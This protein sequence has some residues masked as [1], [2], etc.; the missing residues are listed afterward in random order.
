MA[1]ATTQK[2]AACRLFALNDLLLSRL[3]STASAQDL[4]RLAQTCRQ[5]NVKSVAMSTG[6]EH[7][8]L[9]EAATVH[10]Q[11]FP[12]RHRELAMS[13]GRKGQSAMCLLRQLERVARPLRFEHASPQLKIVPDFMNEK[14]NAATVTFALDGSNS[15][16]H[17]AVCASAASS[18][19]KEYVEFT[20]VDSPFGDREDEILDECWYELSVGLAP[21]DLVVAA[22][23]RLQTTSRLDKAIPSPISNENYWGIQW[24]GGHDGYRETNG[25]L[26]HRADKLGD[27]IWNDY[28][29]TSE[30]EYFGAGGFDEEEENQDSC[31]WASDHRMFADES[32]G[33]NL[34]LLWDADEGLLT[35]FLNG[36]RAGIANSKKWVGEIKG[37]LCWTVTIVMTVDTDAVLPD[38]AFTVQVERRPIPVLSEAE[39]VAEAEQKE[40]AAQAKAN[41]KAEVEMLIDNR[42]FPK[43]PAC[44]R[45]WA[46]IPQEE[47]QY[48]GVCDCGCCDRCCPPFG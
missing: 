20:V 8:V 17:T 24:H 44:Q 16:T 48:C 19:G 34:G 32:K 42:D 27:S 39:A 40:E 28:G 43:C 41:R 31:E 21:R 3:L 9:E 35:V 26:L 23:Q 46:D 36:K 5:A 12:A 25:F 33:Q 29:H 4:G 15:G 47:K 45:R 30:G 14:S 22:Q 38:E 37:E 6:G 13:G 7:S 10:I 2:T 1:T 18:G 11:R